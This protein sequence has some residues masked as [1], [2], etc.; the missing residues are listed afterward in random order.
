M[1]FIIKLCGISSIYGLLF[2]FNFYCLL[3]PYELEI[4]TGWS[5]DKIATVFIVI[6]FLGLVVTSFIIPIA[7]RKLLLGSYHSLWTAI[8]GFLFLLFG[9][10]LSLEYFLFYTRS[11]TQRQLTSRV[12][13]TQVVLL[14]YCCFLSIRCIY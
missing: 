1:P 11:L 3:S 8:L 7:T 5:S 14:L 4:I 10:F 12:T 2:Y 9:C 13:I 6:F